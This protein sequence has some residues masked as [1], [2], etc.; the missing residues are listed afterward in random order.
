MADIGISATGV[1]EGIKKVVILAKDLP[2]LSPN[3]TTTFRYRVVSEDRN[4]V[5]DWSPNTTIALHTPLPVTG[6]ID[7]TSK[8]ITITWTDN[9]EFDDREAYDIFVKYDSGEYSHVGTAYGHSF[10][11][12][13]PVG[14]TTVYVAIQWES[15][16]KQRN[17]LLTIYTGSASLV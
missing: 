15:Y 16:V 13:K 17:G 12:I 4:R 3:N 11:L 6:A 7:V 8:T 5:S 2:P 1:D 14:F 9:E 10:T